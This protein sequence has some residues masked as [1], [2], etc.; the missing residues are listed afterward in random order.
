MASAL[1]SRFAGALFC[2]VLAATAARAQVPAGEWVRDFAQSDDINAAINRGTQGL[3]FIVKPIARKRLRATNPPPQTLSIKSSGNSID[4]VLNNDVVLHTS[5]GA[6]FE[7]SYQGEKLH[8]STT[9][10]G[11][12]L[13]NVFKADDGE[14]SNS[15]RVR[16]DGLLELRTR[17]TSHRLKHPV[18]YV[19]VFRRAAS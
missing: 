2:T 11:G 16:P 6:S 9:L 5:P 19:Q 14:K 13:T 7:W 12:V 4:I 18:E 1:L 3:S 17:I 8:V 15:Y 10:E